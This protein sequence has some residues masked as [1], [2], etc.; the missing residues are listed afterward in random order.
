MSHLEEWLQPAQVYWHT[1]H[2]SQTRSLGTGVEYC[3][4]E[5]YWSSMQSPQSAVQLHTSHYSG[6]LQRLSRHT[7]L[8]TNHWM[9]MHLRTNHWM[10]MH[11]I[12]IV[13]MLMMRIGLLT[14]LRVAGKVWHTPAHSPLDDNAHLHLTS[15]PSASDTADKIYSELIG[16][17]V[18]SQ[19]Q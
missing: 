19:L 6:N 10:I 11:F 15:S 5:W 9:I 3:W 4:G 16:H 1:R 14:P 18:L 7:G 8:R 12:M 13:C 17:G 2:L